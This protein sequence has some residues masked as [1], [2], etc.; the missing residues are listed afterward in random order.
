[1]HGTMNVK[2][3]T[4]IYFVVFNMRISLYKCIVASECAQ[5]R[6]ISEKYIT[7]NYISVKS[8]PLVQL[9]TSFSDC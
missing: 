6:F 2:K 3:K 9:Y 8:V 1:M 7:F 4:S 5:N